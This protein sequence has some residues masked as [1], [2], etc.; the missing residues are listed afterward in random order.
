MSSHRV[1][2][3]EALAKLTLDKQVLKLCLP[4][5]SLKSVRIG[6]TK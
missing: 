1:R 2:K 5:V 6:I 3:V 4:K